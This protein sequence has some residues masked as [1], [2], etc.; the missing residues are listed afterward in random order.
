MFEVR[1][2][3]AA[4]AFIEVVSVRENFQN[5]GLMIH[6]QGPVAENSRTPDGGVVWSVD[7]RPQWMA[8]VLDLG[9]PA[10]D[11]IYAGGIKVWLALIPR[12]GR[13]GSASG[14]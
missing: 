4:V 9:V 1:I 3:D 5:P 2:T 14:H 12:N 6:R 11:I 7:R 8:G 10:E 13:N